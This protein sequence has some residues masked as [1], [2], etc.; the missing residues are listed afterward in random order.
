M[1]GMMLPAA[2]AFGLAVTCAVGSESPGVARVKVDK[3][4][5]EVLA[6]GRE[7]GPSA[8]RELQQIAGRND[9]APSTALARKMLS[10]WSEAANGIHSDVPQAL[11]HPR[12][13][14]DALRRILPGTQPAGLAIVEVAVDARGFVTKAT[15]LKGA[16]SAEVEALILDTTRTMLF[17]PVKVNTGYAPGKVTLTFSLEVR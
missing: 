7:G 17:C 8:R 12:L 13:S 9:G 1:I 16:P 14:A 3:A 4:W 6:L 11:A 10:L 5:D 15:V 2:C